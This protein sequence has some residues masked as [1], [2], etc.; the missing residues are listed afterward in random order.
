M[1][2]FFSILFYSSTEGKFSLDTFHL[3]EKWYTENI[4]LC[5]KYFFPQN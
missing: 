1:F 4:F 3:F 5:F 2:V